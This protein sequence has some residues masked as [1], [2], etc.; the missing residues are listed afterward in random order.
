VPFLEVSDL[1]PLVSNIDAAKAQVMIDDASAVAA[2]H[3][4]CIL[5]PA[6]TNG[7]LVKAILRRAVVRWL[8]AGSGALQQVTVGQIGQTFDNRQDQR[9][10][11]RP[12]EITQLQGLCVKSSA[13]MTLSLAGE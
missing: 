10:M 5:E 8:E 4:P 12:D 9:S 7:A 1:T 3:A 2:S 6:F 11:F 13:S